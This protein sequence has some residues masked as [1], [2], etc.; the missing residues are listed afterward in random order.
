[1]HIAEVEP[2]GEL[3]FCEL[4]APAQDKSMAEI[5]DSGLNVAQLIVSLAA[6]DQDLASVG[7]LGV[8]EQLSCSIQLLDR[9]GH[10]A[11]SEQ[12]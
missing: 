8:S 4:V 12:Q 11:L 5:L 9:I 7:R 10:E 2:R 1:V 6:I 3:Q